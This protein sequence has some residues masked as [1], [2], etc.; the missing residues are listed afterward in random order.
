MVTTA[1][2][3]AH[4]RHDEVQHHTHYKIY[5]EPSRCIKS[6]RSFWFLDVWRDSSKYQ[7]C[8]ILC[9]KHQGI[10]HKHYNDRTVQLMTEMAAK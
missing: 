4:W 2:R 1:Q 5:V 3:N 7:N 6:Y 8:S 10:E 9:S